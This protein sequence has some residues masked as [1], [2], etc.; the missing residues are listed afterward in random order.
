MSDYWWILIGPVIYITV[1]LT[2]PLI[3]VLVEGRPETREDAMETVKLSWAW[4]IIAPLMMIVGILMGAAM[5]V[6]WL[7][8]RL[9]VIGTRYVDV[10]VGH[11]KRRVKG[12]VE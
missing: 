10:L 12:R 1:S 3:A 8:G 7:G 5:L 9:S 4:P 2:L 11:P 6:D